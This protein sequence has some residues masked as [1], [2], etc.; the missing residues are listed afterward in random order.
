MLKPGVGNLSA[1]MSQVRKPL[2]MH[3]ANERIP[4]VPG[5]PVIRVRDDDTKPEPLESPSIP[6]D[7]VLDL[8][9]FSCDV[10]YLKRSKAR[11]RIEAV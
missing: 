6:H 7:E 8:A 11:F 5:N 9:V 10:A 3:V 2:A 1:E 4:R